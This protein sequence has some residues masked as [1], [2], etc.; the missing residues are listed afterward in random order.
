MWARIEESF[1]IPRTGKYH[2]Y[3]TTRP[4]RAVNCEVSALCGTGLEFFNS[5]LWNSE[6]AAPHHANRC[7]RCVAALARREREDAR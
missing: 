2:W 6:I 5:W 1:W 7:K 3:D 4:G